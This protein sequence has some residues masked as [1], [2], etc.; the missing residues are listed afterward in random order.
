MLRKTF[1]AMS[2]AAVAAAATSIPAQAET[3]IVMTPSDPAVTATADGRLVQPMPAARE[4]Y[5]WMPGYWQSEGD[6]Q[7]WIEGHWVPAT[8]VYVRREREHEEHHWWRRH[9]RDDDD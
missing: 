9:H 6:H 4:G 2:I 5:R 1:L 7:I 8:D 3:Y